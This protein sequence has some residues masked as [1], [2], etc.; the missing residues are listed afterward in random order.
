MKAA[1][2]TSFE[3][4]P[5]YLESPDPVP[6][7]QHEI[8]V[9]VLAAGLH[10]RVRSQAAGTHYTS[11]DQLPL[12]PGIDGVGRDADGRLRYFILPDTTQGSM[13]QRTVI[14]TRRSVILPPGADPVQVAA[15]M[16]PAMSSW[17][18]LRRRIEFTPGQSV[19]VLAATG[20]AGRVALQVAKRLG[21]GRVI[22]VG[23]GA[24]R[25]A[26]L[27]ADMK[28]CL[29]DAP[30]LVAA[31]L[32]AAGMDVDVVCDYLWGEPTAQALRAIIPA[33]VDDSQQLTWISIGSVAGP[34]SPI[35]SAA[36]RATRLQLV[37]SG[38]GSV[39]TADI[40]GELGELAREITAGT[41]S[42]ET[43]TVP[44]AEVEQAW[45]AASSSR[46]LVLIP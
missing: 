30:D 3:Q 15:V 29:D 45:D 20:S 41:L 36:L 46:R 21:A 5:R 16:N 43:S 28:V 38:Q 32:A 40:A 10:P 23:R 25:L 9:D 11:T 24:D 33:R 44:L 14:D 2:V 37:G 22:A 39:A 17:V 13:A 19:M 35:P 31:N 6:A 8:V 1:V 7:R 27:D 34:E 12:I 18:A 26:K 4:S 42:V